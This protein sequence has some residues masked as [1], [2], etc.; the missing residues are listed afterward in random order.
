VFGHVPQA[1]VIV[2]VTWSAFWPGLLASPVSVAGLYFRNQRVEA[3]Y[4][5]NWF[6][7]GQMPN[8]RSRRPWLNSSLTSAE[9]TSLFGIGCYA[10]SHSSEATAPTGSSSIGPQRL[11]MELPRTPKDACRSI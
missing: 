4:R 6:S 7:R 3:T 1:L 5:K 8:A 9:I 11:M 10:R 2:A